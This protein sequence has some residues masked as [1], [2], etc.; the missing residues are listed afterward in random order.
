M[1]RYFFDAYTDNDL[2]KDDTGT[3]FDSLENVRE[4]AQQHLHAIGLHEIPTDLDRRT[5]AVLVTDRDGRAVYSATL[6]YAGRWLTR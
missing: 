4:A 3:E 2:Q 5:L 6:S 1:P